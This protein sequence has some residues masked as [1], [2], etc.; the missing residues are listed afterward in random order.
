[1]FSG[2]EGIPESRFA[3]KIE[4]GQ[5]MYLCLG[6][7]EP[8][9][10]GQITSFFLQFWSLDMVII[11]SLS[12]CLSAWR[13]M[14]NEENSRDG[15]VVIGFISNLLCEL[16]WIFTSDQPIETRVV[17]NV[18]NY[19]LADYWKI[20]LGLPLHVHLLTTLTGRAM[21]IMLFVITVRFSS[22]F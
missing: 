2:S 19:W 10:D 9:A 20:L 5:K 1:M 14:Q 18:K 13:A 7:R 16:V 8:I 21:R 4:W 22:V 6:R 11:H 17:V 3:W 15:E 12:V